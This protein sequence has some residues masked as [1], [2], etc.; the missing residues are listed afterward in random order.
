MS[1]ETQSPTTVECKHP[2]CSE[3]GNHWEFRHGSYCSTDCELR[4]EGR[5]V[6]RKLMYDH[7]RCFTCFRELKTVNP[8]KP[9][10]EFTED[11][12]G[13]TLD[14]NGDPTLQY[15]SQ[16]VTRSAATGFQFLTEN[17]GKG[18]KQRGDTVITGTICSKCGNTDHAHHDP[19]LAG[20]QAIGRLAALLDGDDDVVFDAEVLHRVYQRR[21]DLL[22]AVGLALHD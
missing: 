13:W 9:D 21:D 1:T 22:L 8:P 20:R 5:Q 3:I 18:E 10:F 14:E 4:H 2:E 7:C 16:E 6:L 15:Y 19:V 12:H 11:G 17:A